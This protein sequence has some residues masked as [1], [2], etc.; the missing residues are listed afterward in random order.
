MTV[1]SSSPPMQLP[2]E[3]ARGDN[4]GRVDSRWAPLELDDDRPAAPAPTRS[5]L[6]GLG[7]FRSSTTTTLEEATFIRVSWRRTNTDAD[8][9]LFAV[10]NGERWRLRFNGPGSCVSGRSDRDTTP[11]HKWSP[12]T[13]IVDGREIGELPVDRWPPRWESPA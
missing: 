5:A 3:L 8:Y 4:A 2:V 11:F 10:V 1:A 6:D 9:P 13:L 12:L 7:L